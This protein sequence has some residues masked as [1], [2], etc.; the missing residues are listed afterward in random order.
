MKRSKK[1]AVLVSFPEDSGQLW[2]KK[3]WTLLAVDHT[4][5]TL[6]ACCE[7]RIP[8]RTL[9]KFL[10]KYMLHACEVQIVQALKA[11][12]CSRRVEFE[13]MNTIPMVLDSFS[14]DVRI[15]GFGESTCRC[16]ERQISEC[17]LQ[18]YSLRKT[19]HSYRLLKR[20]WG[21]T[22]HLRR[23]SSKYHPLTR[24]S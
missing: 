18:S 2:T 24:V 22:K 19:H 16:R 23:I 21:C 3:I 5:W 6:R 9:L 13:I 4:E 11:T 10:I 7:L 1:L 8:Q 17:S 20:P 14:S 15:R 12:D